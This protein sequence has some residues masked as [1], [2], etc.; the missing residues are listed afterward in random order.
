MYD[1][2]ENQFMPQSMSPSLSS[3]PGGYSRSPSSS[4]RRVSS[5]RNSTEV[6]SSGLLLQRGLTRPRRS[7]STATQQNPFPQPNPQFYSQTPPQQQQQPV[8]LAPIMGENQ[9]LLSPAMVPS[10]PPF[11]SSTSSG[12][13]QLAANRLSRHDSYGS[14]SGGFPTGTSQ[15][16][17]HASY[18]PRD[19]PGSDSY[20]RESFNDSRGSREDFEEE[21]S[22]KDHG[23]VEELDEDMEDEDEYHRQR[24]AKR[25]S[26]NFFA[27]ALQ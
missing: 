27:T 6:G 7:S 14:N 23:R 26:G 20:S 21:G 3:S 17:G 4:A 15:G 13:P 12:P 16:N 9:R 1:H 11:S 25:R 22:H 10:P 8:V 5:H 18:P 24:A 2:H 19:S